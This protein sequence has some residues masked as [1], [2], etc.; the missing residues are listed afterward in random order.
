[1]IYFHSLHRST[2]CVIS[3]QKV[4][5]ENLLFGEF[6]FLEDET[7][8]GFCIVVTHQSRLFEPDGNVGQQLKKRKRFFFWTKRKEMM[9]LEMFATNLLLVC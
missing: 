5:L 6:R 2:E 7:E 9:I 8:K 3:L 4:F 1:V